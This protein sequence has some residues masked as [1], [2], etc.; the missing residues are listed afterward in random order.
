MTYVDTAGPFDGSHGSIYKYNITSK[1]WANIT[2]AQAISDNSY[3]F[4]GV[5]IDTLNPGVV[6]TVSLNEYYPDAE[7]SRSR[8]RCPYPTFV[9]PFRSSG[10]RSMVVNR[11]RIYIPQVTLLP[12]LVQKYPSVVGELRMN[13]L[14]HAVSML[15]K[16]SAIMHGTFPPLLGSILILREFLV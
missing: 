1:T 7:V 13:R 14:L 11:G 5:T 12:M 3:G 2:P 6:M 4:G 15:F 16:S 8:L 9:Y 10:D